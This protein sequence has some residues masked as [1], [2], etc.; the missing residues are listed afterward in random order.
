M[1]H[2]R[3]GGGG[4]VHRM[5]RRVTEKAPHEHVDGLVQGGGEQHPLAFRRGGL[6]QPPHH[7]Q[8]SEVGHVV[9]LVEHADFHIV[10]VAVPLLDEIGQPPRAGDDDVHPVAQGRDLRVLPDAAE[11]GGD[12]QVHGRGQRREDRVDLAGQFPGRYQDQAARAA[13][14]RV[15]V[16][17]AR[18]ER[19]REPQRLA[20]TGPAPAQDVQPGQRVG[21]RGG[22]DRERGRMPAWASEVTSGA[23]TP[24]SAKVSA[25]PGVPRP[26]R[27][28]RACVSSSGTAV[29]QECLPD[30]GGR[31]VEGRHVR[32]N[33]IAHRA[34]YD[35]RALMAAP[36]D[37]TCCLTLSHAS[38]PSLLRSTPVSGA[39]GPSRELP[40][41]CWAAPARDGGPQNG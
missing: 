27:R 8:E 6:H 25:G 30:S 34:T 24:K 36:H 32:G 4:R 23:G 3:R 17:Q 15:P 41:E 22:L 1:D 12:R 13:G 11:D 37:L 21:Q 18:D 35:R 2:G 33:Q 16:G 7:R 14:Q 5:D 40:S 39:A 10:Q 26:G 28:R 19:D 38:H 9:G 29:I 31:I 20:G